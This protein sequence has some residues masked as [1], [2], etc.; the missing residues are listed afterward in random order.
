MDDQQLA[1]NGLNKSTALYLDDH[2]TLPLETRRVLVQLLT[3]PSL[4][5]RRHSK[6]W[7][8]LLRDEQALR[9]QLS[10]LFLGLVIDYD[11]QVAFTR[12]ADTEELDTPKLLRRRDLNF[13]DSALLLYLRQT[14]I[15]ADVQGERAVISHADII[16]YLMM[17]ERANATDHAGFVKRIN[18]AVN[19][20]KEYRILQKIRATD[21]RFEISPTLKLLFSVN[22]VR[23]LTQAFKNM[24]SAA[25]LLSDD[26]TK[27]EAD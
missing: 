20:M 5:G 26:M 4:D 17:Y 12:Q 7:P 9:I 1:N 24:V 13:I 8:V 11:L 18:S 19:R 25:S 14:L 3:G 27:E 10:E 6:L 22:E 23:A 2:G 16:N 15:E 21:D